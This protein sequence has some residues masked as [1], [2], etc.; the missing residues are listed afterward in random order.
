MNEEER[1]EGYFYR[2]T[3]IKAKEGWMGRKKVGYRYRNRKIKVKGSKEGGKE[4]RKH[5]K[6]KAKRRK[7]VNIERIKLK[8]G[9]KETE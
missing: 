9:W 1:K 4:G 8:D 3:K 2:N 7:E 5:I 6:I